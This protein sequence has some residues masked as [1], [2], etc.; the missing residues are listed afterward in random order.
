MVTAYYK[1]PATRNVGGCVGWITSGS[2]AYYKVPATR[3]VGGCV[4][5]VASRSSA[6]A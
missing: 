6:L 4:G 3:Y 1:V 5:W 2:S